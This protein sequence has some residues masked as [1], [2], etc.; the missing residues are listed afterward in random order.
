MKKI[1]Y[2]IPFLMFIVI[3][4]WGFVNINMENTKV[5]NS[6]DSEIS[7]MD[8]DKIKE[9]VGIDLTGFSE[10][11]SNLKMYR[12]DQGFY[13]IYKD[14]VVNL[15]EGVFGRALVAMIDTINRSVESVN[16]F[17]EN[18]MEEY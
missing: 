2:I 14:Y 15:N 8:N 17:M 12:D 16:L 7:S 3:F 11:N 5:F 1:L 9:E 4:V 10:D 13:V 6:K 18:I